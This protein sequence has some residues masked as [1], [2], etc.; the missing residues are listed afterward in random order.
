MA[1]GVRRVPNPDAMRGMQEL[2]AL[3]KNKGKVGWF[4]SAK[5]PDGTPVAYVALIQEMGSPQNSIPPR[6]FFRSTMAEKSKQWTGL[7][8]SGCKAIL[9]G[10]ETAHSV[11]EKVTGKAA[12]DVR[13]KISKIREPALSQRTLDARLSRGLTST[14]PLV[15]TGIMLQTLT[16]QVGSEP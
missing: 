5:Y 4:E 15:D 13:R 2:I 7:L 1:G 11:M 12:G 14:K 8:K 3:S 6:P 9:A 16:H 10:N